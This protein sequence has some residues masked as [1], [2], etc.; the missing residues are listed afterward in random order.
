MESYTYKGISAGKY[1]E[2]EINALN[3]EEAAHKLKQ[4]KVIITNIT[5]SK[6]N[7]QKRKLI[8]FILLPH[9]IDLQSF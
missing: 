1:V 8:N 6:K 4:D 9:K 7:K 5:K 2:G 3:Q